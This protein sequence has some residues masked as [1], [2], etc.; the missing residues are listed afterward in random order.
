MNTEIVRNG[1]SIIHAQEKSKTYLYLSVLLHEL[2]HFLTGLFFKVQILTFQVGS[3]PSIR[4]TFSNIKF[5]LGIISTG[6]Y[7][8]FADQHETTKKP[9]ESL[10]HS[11][12]L[13]I[14]AFGPFCNFM[15]FGVFFVQLMQAQSYL[16]GFLFIILSTYEPPMTEV[17]GFWVGAI[18]H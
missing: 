14:T 3:G 11:Q 18:A 5:E 4:F 10:T 7:V 8:E 2:G 17:T 6:G 15:L 13:L 9:Y 12:N 1:Y 16:S